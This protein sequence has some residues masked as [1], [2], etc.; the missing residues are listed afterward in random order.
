MG[1]RVAITGA[2][3]LIGGALS[4]ALTARGDEVIHLVRR[5]ART[6]GEVTWDPVRGEIA[7]GALDGVDAVVNLAGVG[8][9]DRRWSAGYKAEIL[10]SRVNSTR[11][12]AKAL[13]LAAHP[14]RVVNASA[15]GYYGTGHGDEPLP[16]ETPAGSSFLADVCVAWEAETTPMTEAGHNVT[17]LRTGIVLSREGGAMSKVLPLARAGVFGPL[18]SGQQ[19]WPWITLDDEVSVLLWL[20]RRP[21]VTGPVNACAPEAARQ[22]TIADCIGAHLRKP[23]RVPAPKLALKA[24]LG[25]FADELLASQRVVPAQLERHG[26]TFAHPHLDGAVAWMLGDPSGPA[27][28]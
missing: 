11:T 15:V 1:Q 21:D 18:G 23:S 19:F 10:R 24:A 6:T 27:A 22:A 5:P 25:G 9:G 7:P 20:I 26:F 12:L 14:M 16:E 28:G 2:S 17:L 8:V 4:S 3:G 13:R